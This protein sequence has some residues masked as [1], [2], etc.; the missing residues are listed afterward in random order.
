MYIYI[1]IYIYISYKLLSIN[2]IMLIILKLHTL[3]IQCNIENIKMWLQM[4]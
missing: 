3:L 2:K 1:Y 4:V